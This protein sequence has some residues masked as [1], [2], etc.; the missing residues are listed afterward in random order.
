MEALGGDCG[1][2]NRAGDKQ[3]SL[4]WFCFPYRP[5]A[6]GEEA[7]C[8]V[9][10]SA[11]SLSASPSPSLPPLRILMVEDT[12]SVLKVCK[13][14][15]E[16]A[17]HVVETALNGNQCLEKLKVGHTNYDLVISDIQMPVMVSTGPACLIPQQ[18]N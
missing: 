14:F 15:L 8:A 9:E 11:T 4:F 13:R 2:R 16:K 18:Q 12:A 3:G 1:V 7:L 17:G 6:T 5:D 10:S